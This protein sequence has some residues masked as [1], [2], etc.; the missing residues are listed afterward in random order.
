MTQSTDPP[1]NAG[2]YKGNDIDDNGDGQ[3]NDSDTVDGS[4]AADL[5]G[6]WT[7]D[8]N[9]PW[10]GG[11]GSSLTY[12]I[13][14]WQVADLYRVVLML[15]ND[16]GASQD[17]R[18]RMDGHTDAKYDYRLSD[19]TTTTDASA[20]MLAKNVSDGR[21]FHATC[22]IAN[23]ADANNVHT[24]T[25]QVGAGDD[26]SQATLINGRYPFDSG[27]ILEIT[28]LGGGAGDVSVLGGRVWG[29]T[30]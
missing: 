7:E 24:I 9:S 2:R 8:S 4:N 28:V 5:G 3:V 14:D 15:R 17:V 12:D 25:A 29:I 16:A 30:L 23:E 6:A 13:S 21:K 22:Q 26:P 10:A 18:L 20:W 27:R 19:G 11:T 1:V